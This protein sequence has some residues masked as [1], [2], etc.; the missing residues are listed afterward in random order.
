MS[1]DSNEPE[2]Q[3]TIFVIFGITG[4]LAQ[5]YLLPALYH[6]FKDGKL[7]DQTEIVGITRRDITAEDLLKQTELCVNE[8]DKVCD[9]EAL[10]AMHRHTR[11]VQMDLNDADAYAK[12]LQTLN[13][14]EDETGVCMNRLY[15]L[16]IPPQVYA[17]VIQHLGNQGLS[18]SCQHGQASS[19]LLIE[20]PFGYDLQSARDLVQ[21]TGSVFDE[22]QIFRID[23]FLAKETAQNILTFRF[24]NPIFEPLWNAE[25]IASIDIATSEQIGIEGRVQFYEPL[26]ALRDFIQNHLLQ[27]LAITTMDQPAALDSDSIHRSK[28]YLLEQ[29]QPVPADKVADN[30]HRGQYKGYREEVN[31]PDSATET[32]A[33]IT[34]FIDSER[35]RN[36]PMRLWTGKNLHEKNYDITVNFRSQAD[37]PGN[38]LI[39]HIQPNEGIELDLLAKKPG[40]D[41]K[42]QTAAMDFSYQQNFDDHGHPN[43][44]E[45]VLVDAVKGD[46]TLFTTSEEVLA[47]W[48]VVQ[49]ILDE[50]SKNSSDLMMYEPGSS[51]PLDVESSGF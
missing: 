34:I 15:Y 44:Y 5:R 50:W 30:A 32:Y 27:L 4:D 14:I 17:P 28:Q 8:I 12:L 38:R 29:I 7:H 35:W 48:R 2:L 10:A 49:P 6:L 19:R 46:H 22:S 21:E 47:S 3:P 16:S 9:P 39:F 13:G 41:D 24:K 36:V 23:H 33:D 40:F 18:G 43:A 1:Q 42:L 31:N 37:E 51:G 20:K 11:M 45:R 26:G 25:H